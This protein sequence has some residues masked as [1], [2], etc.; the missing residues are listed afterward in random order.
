MDEVKSRARIPLPFAAQT[1]IDCKHS[2]ALKENGSKV[3]LVKLKAMGEDY[4]IMNDTEAFNSFSL[5]LIA[6]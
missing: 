5:Q 4:A 1:H 2:L 6:F 3:V